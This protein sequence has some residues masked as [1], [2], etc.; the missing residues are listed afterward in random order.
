MYYKMSKKY[1]HRYVSEPNHGAT[2][3]HGGGENDYF[4]KTWNASY[5]QHF[6]IHSASSVW[7]YSY[8]YVH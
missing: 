8:V 6:L 7:H 3:Y 2:S 4:Q 5:N 1:L